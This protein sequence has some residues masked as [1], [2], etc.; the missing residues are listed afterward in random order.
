MLI[1]SI[2]NSLYSLI[3]PK[4][5]SSLYMILL[6]ICSCL[7]IHCELKSYSRPELFLVEA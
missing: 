6:L 5:A 1:L 2:A 3:N 7:Y 4:G